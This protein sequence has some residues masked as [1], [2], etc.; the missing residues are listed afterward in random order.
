MP[1]SNQLFEGENILLVSI[2]GNWAWDE[3][4]EVQ[5]KYSVIMRGFNRRFDLILDFTEA[6]QTPPSGGFSK[7]ANLTRRY[8]NK[9]KRSCYLGY[10]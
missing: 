1:V 5:E 7:M 4:Y 3:F 9:D 10:K 8:D 6:T 2:N